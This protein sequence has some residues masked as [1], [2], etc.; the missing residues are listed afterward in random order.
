MNKIRVGLL[1]NSAH[2]TQ[3]PAWLFK[4]LERIKE[5]AYA[6]ITLV[7][8]DVTPGTRTSRLKGMYKDRNN[9]LYYLYRKYENKTKNNG[10]NAFTPKPV[11]PFLKGT[12]VMEIAMEQAK[13]SD[14]LQKADIDKIKSYDLDV[15]LFFGSR[16]LKGEILNVARYGVWSYHHGDNLTYRGHPACAWEF[17]EDY[18]VTGSMLQVLTEQLDGGNVLY[19]SYSQTDPVSIQSNMNKVYWKTLSFV[20]RMLKRLYDDRENFFRNTVAPINRHPQFYSNRLYTVPTNYELVSLLSK[21]FFKKV[22]NK[23]RNIFTETNW[24]LFYK[25]SRTTEPA[26]SLY[27][28]KKL[29]PPKGDFWADPHVLYKDNKYYLF[30]EEYINAIGKGRISVIEMDEKGKYSAPVPVLETEYH[31]SYPF[32]FEDQGKYYMVPET[33]TSNTIQLYESVD[34]PYKWEFRMN[35]MEN[36]KAVDP[37]LFFYN[38][39]WWLFTNICENE[40]AMT[41]DEL[42]LFSSDELLTPNWVPHPRNPVVSDVRTARPGGSIFFYNDGLYRCSQVSAPYYGSGTSVNHIKK[43]TAAEYEEEQVNIIGPSWSKDIKG[44]HTLSFAHKLTVIDA[45]V[46]RRK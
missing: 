46:K 15:L 21:K 17:L 19:R 42:Y 16:I 8:K 10:L 37:N 5:S 35:L 25:I 24:V 26:F 43:L 45:L 3:I 22:K 28:Y 13:Y 23:L 32:V 39:K 12:P 7:I 34:F 41:L 31:I 18:P 44:T 40:G 4:M 9:L 1:L 29:M 27:Q 30:I 20:P 2:N 33:A 11:E 6:E 38:N 36:V 14:N